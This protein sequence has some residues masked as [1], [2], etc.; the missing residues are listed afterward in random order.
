MPQHESLPAL[1]IA[2]AVTR[3]H[4]DIFAEEWHRRSFDSLALVDTFAAT[5][6][7]EWPTGTSD[8]DSAQD[9]FNRIEDEIFDL[10]YEELKPAVA[11]AFLGIARKVL[12]RERRRQ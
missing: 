6:L 9:R 5:K 12:A 3:K 1:H 11:E 7:I 4:A 2:P 10:L 8:D